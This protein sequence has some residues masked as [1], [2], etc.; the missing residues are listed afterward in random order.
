MYLVTVPVKKRSRSSTE[1]FSDRI[2]VGLRAKYKSDRTPIC[3]R[4]W[5]IWVRIAFTS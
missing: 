5:W 2:S 3:D 1:R 4:C